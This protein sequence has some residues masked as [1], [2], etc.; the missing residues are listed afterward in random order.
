MSYDIEEVTFKRDTED[1]SNIDFS[2]KDS[3]AAICD[4]DLRYET[5][6]VVSIYSCLQSCYKALALIFVT[7]LTADYCDMKMVSSNNDTN[8]EGAHEPCQRPGDR[9]YINGMFTALV[10]Y[11]SLF[12][13]I[14]LTKRIK[15]IWTMKILSLSAIFFNFLLFFCLP[16]LMMYTSFGMLIFTFNGISVV[17][18]IILPKLYPTVARNAGFGLVDGISKIVASVFTFF[19]IIL[20]NSSIKGSIGAV[21]TI[22]A[23]ILIQLFAPGLQNKLEDS[24]ECA[25]SGKVSE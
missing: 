16:K 9:D 18:Y 10:L 24:D 25:N 21:M 20:L 22:S 4:I 3:F 6:R 2:L 8:I 11:I 19:I 23:V 17:F 1:T 15:E 14:Y 5:F 12:V 7:C 13:T